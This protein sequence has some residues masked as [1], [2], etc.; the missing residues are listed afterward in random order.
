VWGGM[1]AAW[2]V[3]RPPTGGG[4]LAAALR[5]ADHRRGAVTRIWP[6]IAG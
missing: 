3:G 2:A 6:D 4:G 1:T 5:K